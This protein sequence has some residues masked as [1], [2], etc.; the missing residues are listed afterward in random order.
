MSHYIRGQDPVR[1]EQLET[2]TQLTRTAKL[3]TRC[4]FYSGMTPATNLSGASPD[5]TGIRT[6]KISGYLKIYVGKLLIVR[7]FKSNIAL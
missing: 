3:P 2:S 7:H 1:T 4:I 5:Q 6:E